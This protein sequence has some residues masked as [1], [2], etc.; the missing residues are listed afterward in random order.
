MEG[1]RCHLKARVT[2]GYVK[3]RP[4]DEDLEDLELQ[5][6][7]SEDEYDDDKNENEDGQEAI[8]SCDSSAVHD[9]HQEHENQVL[10][11]SADIFGVGVGQLED[12]RVMCAKCAVGHFHFSCDAAIAEDAP[13][14]KQSHARNLFKNMGM[15]QIIRL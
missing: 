11:S 6:M 4:L 10:Y 5:I 3:A 1:E 2:A 14:Q 13:D 7:E 15:G 9:S 8:E 12:N